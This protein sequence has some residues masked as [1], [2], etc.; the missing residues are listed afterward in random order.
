MEQFCTEVTVA[1]NRNMK[2]SFRAASIVGG[3]RQEG[4]E[5]D[6]QTSYPIVS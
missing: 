2:K 4:V 5:D 3:H 6:G 1:I